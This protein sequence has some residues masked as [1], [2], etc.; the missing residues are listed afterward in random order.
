MV[1]VLP[2]LSPQSGR[3]DR[4]PATPARVRRQLPALHVG[5]ADG[6][7]RRLPRGPPGGRAA[8]A[9]AGRGRSDQPGTVV[10]PHGRVPLLGRDDHPE[11]SDGH[12]PRRRLRRCDGRR[13]SARHVRSHRADAADSPPGGIRPR[14]GLAR[15]SLGH[16]EERVLLGVPRRVLR[17]RRVPPRRLQQ[18]RGP[19]R[20]RKSPAPAHRAT[21][22]KRSRRSSWA[23][24]CA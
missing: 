1:Q 12:R 24:C 8:P 3:H 2:G 22:S 4:R 20:R 13:L 17:A 18:R 6:R 14:R 16:H 5:R 21:S 10:H 19:A 9:C 7:G 23:T 15:R 11:P